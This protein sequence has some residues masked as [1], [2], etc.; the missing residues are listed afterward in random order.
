MIFN[1][2][3]ISQY[4][5]FEKFLQSNNNEEEYKIIFNKLFKKYKEV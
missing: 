4:S 2:F 3:I 1:H 5:L